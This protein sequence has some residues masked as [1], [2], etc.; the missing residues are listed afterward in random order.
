M[1]ADDGFGELVRGRRAEL[2]LTIEQL[3]E[4][5]GLSVRAI[6]DIERGRTGQPRR[7]S[8]GLLAEAL[9][10]AISGAGGPA[11]GPD[12]GRPA[13]ASG[14]I[15]PRQLPAAVPGFAGRAAELV[16]LTGLL[17]GVDG[18]C[19]RPVVAVISGMAGI[20]KTALAVHWAHQAAG[21]FPDGQLYAD[22]RGFILSGP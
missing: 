5:T 22:L 7:S 1:T 20:G 2:G 9:G 3:A 19:G 10:T 11:A 8:V 17:E 21:R 18:D 4:Q 14:M 15:T 6:S 13:A 12:A 16:A